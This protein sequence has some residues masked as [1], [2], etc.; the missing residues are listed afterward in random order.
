MLISNNIE[1]DISQISPL[2]MMDVQVTVGGG[3]RRESIMAKGSKQVDDM[4]VQR[5]ESDMK[6]LK[7]E[8]DHKDKRIG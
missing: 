1:F 7:R 3:G 5:L 6:E 8:R 2:D 4:L